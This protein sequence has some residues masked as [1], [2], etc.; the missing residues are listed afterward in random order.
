MM[1]ARWQESLLP[2]V[3]FGGTMCNPFEVDRDMDRLR[4]IPA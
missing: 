1:P 4:A 3:W 2:H